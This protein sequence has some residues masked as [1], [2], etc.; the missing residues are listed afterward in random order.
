[1]RLTWTYW[2][3]RFRRNDAIPRHFR[4]ADAFSLGRK[5]VLRWGR[6]AR[7][8]FSIPAFYGTILVVISLYILVLLYW[9]FPF[10]FLLLWR[11]SY[12]HIIICVTT[13]K[14]RIL[15][16]FLLLLLWKDSYCHIM[17]YLTSI[18]T[19]IPFFIP[20]F[21]GRIPTI[22][23]PYILLLLQRGF[24]VL[25]LLLREDSYY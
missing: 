12:C 17:I 20:A 19:R 15:F 6:R 11:D 1:M 9:W 18:I 10:L 4:F 14:T 3:R 8:P 7:I 21:Y 2:S 22:V 24:T 23:F 16:L 5:G 13:I 25:F